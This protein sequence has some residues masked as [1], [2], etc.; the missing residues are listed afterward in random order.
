[1]NRAL[2]TFAEAEA[3]NKLSHFTV[4]GFDLNGVI[5]AGAND[6]EEIYNYMRFGI[7]YII[8]FEPL[9]AAWQLCHDN[10]KKWKSELNVS[11]KMAICFPIALDNFNGH[12]ELNITAGDGKGSSLLRPN[13]EHPE[14]KKNWQDGQDMI[15]DKAE[16]QVRRLDEIALE[17]DSGLP[18]DQIDTLVLDT[19]G[20]EMEILEGM[21]DYL[22]Q[23]KYLCIELSMTPAY[24]GEKLGPDVAAWLLERGFILDS[25]ELDHNDWFFVRKDIKPVSDKVYRG[26]C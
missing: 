11:P 12:A 17:T 4:Q 20:N 18:W 5:H 21:G 2:P 13:P 7:D 3:R 25:P 24:D 14:V 16:V 23:F 10:I 26:K 8:G 19:Q 22:K 1:M 15:V 9:L 6:G